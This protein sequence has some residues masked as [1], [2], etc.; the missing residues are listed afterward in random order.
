MI[1]KISV[2]NLTIGDQAAK[3]LEYGDI[4]ESCQSPRPERQED[5]CGEY[6]QSSADKPVL[7]GGNSSP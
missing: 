7:V 6:G 3:E 1:E 4:A 2:R 5:Q